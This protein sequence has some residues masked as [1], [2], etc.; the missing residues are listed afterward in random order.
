MSGLK[1]SKRDGTQ[2]KTMSVLDDFC[3]SIMD[4]NINKLVLSYE[5]SSYEYPLVCELIGIIKESVHQIL[6]EPFNRNIL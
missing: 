5:K 2:Q 3:T 4:N 6:H 1:G